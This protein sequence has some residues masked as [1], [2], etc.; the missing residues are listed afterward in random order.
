MRSF[1]WIAGLSVALLVQGRAQA[2]ATLDGSTMEGAPQSTQSPCL[3]KAWRTP[4]QRKLAS[5]LLCVLYPPAKYSP[6]KLSFRQDKQGRVLVDVRTLS[7]LKVVERVQSLGGRVVYTSA[8]YHSVH[9]YL[10]PGGLERLA[11]LDEVKF[12]QPVS[13]AA[14]NPR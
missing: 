9:G 1:S 5:S 2:P 8:R 12:I 13:K 6:R 14:T 3:D 11:E 4:A 10:A 7:P